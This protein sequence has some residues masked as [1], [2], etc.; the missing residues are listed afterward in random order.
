MKKLIK[1]ILAIVILTIFAP[2]CEQEPTRCWTCVVKVYFRNPSYPPLKYPEGSYLFCDLP[3]SKINEIEEILNVDD[4][5]L[6]Q[7]CDCELT[8]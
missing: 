6:V 3:E 1:L 2:S 7:T 8:R 5:A 4:E